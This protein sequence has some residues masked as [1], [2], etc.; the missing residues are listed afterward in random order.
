MEY[1]TEQWLEKN[2]DQLPAS[3]ANLLMGS[4]F[5][6]LSKIQ[7][8]I[9]TE[10]REGRGSV[11]TKSVGA[12]FSAQLTQLRSRI[13]ATVPHYI[14]CLKPN[15]ELVPDSFDPRMIVDQLRC[16]GVLEAVRVSRAGY[17]T[18]Y[19]HDVFRA[20]YYILGENPAAKKKKGTVAR[21]WGSNASG[22]SES[23][24]VKQLVS[25][26][27]Y[28]IWEA[29]HEAMMEALEENDGTPVAVSGWC[30]FAF[31]V[32]EVSHLTNPLSCIYRTARA[33]PS[34]APSTS[35]AT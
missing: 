7:P 22:K 13:D 10:D 15:D 18:R 25:K 4:G 11:A 8:F 12:Q 23:S 9:R 14:R 27:A 6:L 28:D 3:S 33:T 32:R 5:D 17:P 19:P 24:D 31:D 29:D 1:G 16:G 20:R 2:K 26:I 35:T 34:T 21:K 30:C